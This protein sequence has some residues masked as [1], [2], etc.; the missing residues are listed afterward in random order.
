MGPYSQAIK[1]N[2][3]VFLSGQ[4]GLIPG[5]SHAL[6]SNVTMTASLLF[7]SV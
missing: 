1:T 7:S 6:P 5:V 4:V 3:M 2:N